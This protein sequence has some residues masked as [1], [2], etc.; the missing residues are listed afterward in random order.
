MGL[1]I[2]GV[3]WTS[4]S[5]VLAIRP[6]RPSTGSCRFGPVQV[7]APDGCGNNGFHSMPGSGYLKRLADDVL[8]F[9]DLCKLGDREFPDRNEELRA[10][11]IISASSQTT[12][13]YLDFVGDAVAFRVFAG[14][15][16]HTA[17]M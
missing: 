10:K 4:A 16:R 11:H 1:G 6:V 3:A 2:S 9:V 15:Q 8:K 14:K 5:G 12:V 13:G 7:D 17:A